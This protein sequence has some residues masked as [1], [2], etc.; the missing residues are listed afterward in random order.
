MKRVMTLAGVSAAILL[1]VCAG[2]ADA[3][4]EKPQPP[5]K[6]KVAKA[7]SAKATAKA[8]DKAEDRAEKAAKKEF[9]EQPHMLLKGIKLTSAE[10]KQVGDIEKRYNEQFKAL[11]KQ[12]D[13][14]EKSGTP[15]T[16]VPQRMATLRD[17]E[18]NDLRAVLTPA[19]QSQFDKNATAPRKH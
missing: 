6:S 8:A 16:D 1:L 15:M 14:A 2:A 10:K 19:Q 7:P 12:E 5:A 3:Q 9:K 18:R 17:Q 4:K 13:Q 11:E